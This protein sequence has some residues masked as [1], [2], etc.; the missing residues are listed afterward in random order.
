[1]GEDSDFAYDRIHL[2]HADPV[3]CVNV[4]LFPLHLKVCLKCLDYNALVTYLLMLSL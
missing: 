3:F 1:M 2:G 4:K